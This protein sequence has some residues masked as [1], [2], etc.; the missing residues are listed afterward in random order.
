MGKGSVT[1]PAFGQRQSW[2]LKPPHDRLTQG[3][4]VSGFAHLPWAEA[5]FL[6]FGWSQNG[7]SKGA[8]LRALNAVACVTDAD[9]RESQ[10]AAVAFTW[11]GLKK[12]GLEEEALGTFSRPFRE[13]MYQED[14]L[15]RLR[16]RVDGQWQPTVIDGGPLWSGNTPNVGG[17]QTTTPKTVHAILLLY[18]RDDT[19]LRSWAKEIAQAVAPYSVRVNHGLSLWFEHLAQKTGHEHFGFADGISQPIPYGDSVVLSDGQSSAQDPWHGVPLGEILMGHPNVHDETAPG[20]FVPDDPAGKGRESRLR[21]ESAPNG[22]LDLGLDGSYLVVRE[23][24]QDVAAF[25]NSMCEGAESIRAQ[26]RDPGQVTAQWLAERVVG[27]TAEGHLLCPGGSLAADKAGQPQNAVGFLEADPFG[28]GCPVGSHVRRANPRDSLAKDTA[29]G[30][31][32]LRA[33]NNH[34]ILRR[35]RN[36]GRPI[37]DRRRHDGEE[38]GLLFM[39]LN[40][41]LARQFEFVQQTWV[42]NPNFATL[43]DQT[44]PLIGP[45]GPFTIQERPLRRLV[46]VETFVKLAGGE[47]FFLPSIAALDYLSRL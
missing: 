22:F 47:Y 16:D 5:L 7:L 42:L 32:S 19:E 30:Q 29:S 41:D 6:N 40:T 37:A 1:G 27:R 23:L 35:C 9:G 34:R 44:D 43:F 33:A 4:V 17:R 38:R 36:Y 46:E 26:H 39:C 15:R 31:T 21:S 18:G 2:K 25:W 24:R 11:T 45:Q 3:L 12:L 20:P 10:A 8:W 13:G 28:Y 14:R